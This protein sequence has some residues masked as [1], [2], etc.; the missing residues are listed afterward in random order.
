MELGVRDKVYMIAGA[1]KGLGYGVAEV[2]ATEGASLAISSRDA[3]AIE[4]AAVNLRQAGAATVSASICDVRR[5]EDVTRWCEEVRSTFG[6]IDGLVVN[7]GGPPPGDF[8]D[9]DDQ[10]WQAAFELTL[11]SAIRL[12]RAALPGLRT[13]GGAILLLTSSSVREP[14]DGL[15]LSNVMRAGV[16]SLAKSL[17]RSLATDGIRVNTLIPGLMDTDRIRA[18]AANLASAAGTS[19]EVQRE[20]M[21]ASIPLARLGTPAEFGRAGAFLLS[22]AASYITGANLVVDGGAM[23]SV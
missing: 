19:A 11:L 23:R 5:A 12:I 7:A 21:Q 14:I 16:H 20:R 15:L 3:E 10:Q 8:D 13:R 18:L 4:S 9:L 22:P 6:A 17:S 1:S 2:L